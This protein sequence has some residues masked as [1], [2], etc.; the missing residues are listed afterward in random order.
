MS[1]LGRRGM[2]MRG[3]AIIW[4][5]HKEAK[6]VHIYGI[7][8]DTHMG[9]ERADDAIV[10]Q[11]AIIHEES[12]LLQDNLDDWRKVNF[13]YFFHIKEKCEGGSKKLP[14]LSPGIH[15][16]CPLGNNF[17]HT[18]DKRII[19]RSQQGFTKYKSRL[20]CYD[21]MTGHVDEGRE[22]DAIYFDFI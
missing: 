11:L 21:E 1:S 16:A 18:K 6:C 5:I 2:A 13:T 7:K 12:L 3:R 9:A 20:T 4:W 10:T 14:H 17:Q 22:V 19:K 15:G 8:W